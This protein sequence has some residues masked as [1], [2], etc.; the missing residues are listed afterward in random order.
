MSLP[1]LTPLSN[2]KGKSLPNAFLIN[3]SA[4]IAA[5]ALSSCLPPWLDTCI[6]STPYA[7]IFKASSGDITPLI[8]SFPFQAFRTLLSVPQSVAPRLSLLTNLLPLF[9]VS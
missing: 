6:A 1:P 9:D 8:I 7:L 4:S 5:V 2:S 3:G